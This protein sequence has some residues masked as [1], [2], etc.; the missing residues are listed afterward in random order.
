MEK[1]SVAIALTTVFLFPTKKPF[2][3][4]RNSYLKNFGREKYVRI[5]T[6][7][8]V[9]AISRDSTKNLKVILRTGN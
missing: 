9:T 6:G 3:T 1:Q 7:T 8:E 2:F 4:C 5:F